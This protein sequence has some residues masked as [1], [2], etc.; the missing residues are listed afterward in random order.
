MR[1][2]RPNQHT[3]SQEAH[4]CLDVNDAGSVLICVAL[5]EFLLNFRQK[6]PHFFDDVAFD[7]W[8]RKRFE[9]L[10]HCFKTICDFIEGA[11]PLWFTGRTTGAG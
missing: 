10:C 8:V 5:L 9:C 7:R 1:E 6:G 2:E 4:R 11:G 3:L